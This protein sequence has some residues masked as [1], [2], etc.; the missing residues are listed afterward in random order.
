MLSRNIKTFTVAILFTASLFPLT[1]Q[2]QQPSVTDDKCIQSE[3]H[4]SPNQKQLK[5]LNTTVNPA[6]L[7]ELIRNLYRTDPDASL[8]NK[9][10]K[11]CNIYATMYKRLDS[12]QAY[13][14][15]LKSVAKGMQEQGYD[16]SLIQ[17]ALSTQTTAYFNLEQRYTTFRN[18]I[19]EHINGTRPF[20]K[21]AMKLER[22][23]IFDDESR[24]RLAI[25]NITKDIITLKKTAPPTPSAAPTGPV[26][27]PAPGNHS[28]LDRIRTIFQN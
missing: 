17:S 21:A 7:K 20:P 28:M 23:A 2:A 26:T 6:K 1:I 5:K 25:K 15:Y 3:I 22:N 11:Y 19:A 14:V 16:M 27:G 10:R 8:Q 9:Q 24:L 12:Y 4:P 18:R 13:L